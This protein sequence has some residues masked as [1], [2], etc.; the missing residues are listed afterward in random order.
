MA[1][2][3]Q[4]PPLQDLDPN[5]KSAIVEHAE[6]KEVLSRGTWTEDHRILLLRQCCIE[7]CNPIT[8]RGNN[9]TSC[10]WK[11]LQ[12]ALRADPNR[13]FDGFSLSID[14]LRRHVRLVLSRQ[15]KR[16]QQARADT[17]RGGTNVRTEEEELAQHLLEQHEQMER[18]RTALKEGRAARVS[19]LDAE[20]KVH[21]TCQLQTHKKKRRSEDPA[22][23]CTGVVRTNGVA[24][25][26]G[27]NS[28]YKRILQAAVEE[29]VRMRAGE[30]WMRFY[31]LHEA[32]PEKWPDPGT[33]MAYVEKALEEHRKTLVSRT[34]DIQNDSVPLSSELE[35]EEAVEV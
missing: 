12:F 2:Q 1:H 28:P 24:R 25:W 34:S 18:E 27:S 8:K 21:L 4:Q 9:A 33:H 31:S 32:M 5:A 13:M 26:T 19:K 22:S 3:R 10:A 14:S 35:E 23:S 17:G 29:R 11:C 30:E 15:R 7:S 6:N 20:G 16:N